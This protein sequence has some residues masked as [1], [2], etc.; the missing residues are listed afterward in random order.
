M[1]GLRFNSS[2]EEFIQTLLRSLDQ[3]IRLYGMAVDEKTTVKK[4][5]KKYPYTAEYGNEML[6]YLRSKKSL[7]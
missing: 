2:E 1:K 6:R 4:Y 3:Y 7:H 5:M